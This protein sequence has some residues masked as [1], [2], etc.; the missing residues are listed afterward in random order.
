MRSMGKSSAVML[1]LLLA[2]LGYSQTIGFADRNPFDVKLPKVKVTKTGAYIGVQAGQFYVVEFGGERQ[3]NRMKLNNPKTHA[4]HAGFNYNFK[5]NVL[6]YDIGYW[7]KPNRLGLTYGGSICYRTDFV[8][9]RFGIIPVV[10]YK[11]WQFHLQTGYHFLTPTPT[12][13]ETNYLFVSLRLVLINE[14]DWKFKKKNG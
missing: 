3:W 11:I 8:H 5:Y 7:Y 14:R 1:A 12:E 9:N 13:F 4:M 6:G 10:G 2:R